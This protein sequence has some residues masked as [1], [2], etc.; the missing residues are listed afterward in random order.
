MRCAHLDHKGRRCLKGWTPLPHLHAYKMPSPFG[1]VSAE[2]KH[3]RA[4][5]SE[6][7]RERA[8]GYCQV[9]A[10]DWA[11]VCGLTFRHAGEHPHHLRLRSQGGPDDLSNGLWVCF[12]A[13]RWIHDHPEAAER[14]GL[15]ESRKARA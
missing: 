1:S 3:A 4:Q 5:F 10:D 12:D 2:K 13:H 14:L 6:A 15:L 9:G 8:G 11:H 7:V